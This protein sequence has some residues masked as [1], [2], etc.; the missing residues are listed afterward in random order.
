[1]NLNSDG[2]WSVIFGK[3]TLSV[4]F[5]FWVS[6]SGNFDKRTSKKLDQSLVGIF[7]KQF[8]CS[9][10][11]LKE[12]TLHPAVPQWLHGKQQQQQHP[13]SGIRP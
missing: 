13:A 10:V 5:L 11:H 9:P 2:Q 7:E 4:L 6:L 12:M 1:M 8:T 3:T